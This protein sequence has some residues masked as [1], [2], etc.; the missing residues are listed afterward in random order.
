MSPIVDLN[1]GGVT[2]TTT[3][4]TLLSI[5]DSLLAAYFKE[6]SDLKLPKDSQGRYFID[7][8][9]VL[10]RYILDYM[11]NRRLILPENFMERERLK[12]EVRMR[13]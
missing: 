13:G 6:D 4:E 9:G 10:F 2:Y 11:R 7:R 3:K 12:Y 1:V 8:D 5:K